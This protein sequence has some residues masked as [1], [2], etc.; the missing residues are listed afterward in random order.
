[1]MV[2]VGG[3]QKVKGETEHGRKWEKVA[4]AKVGGGIEKNVRI[5]CECKIYW[6]WEETQK[7]VTGG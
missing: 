2:Y 3:L 7:D 5:I 4:D 6:V 1:M